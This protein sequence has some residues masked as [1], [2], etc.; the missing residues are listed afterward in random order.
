MISIGSSCLRRKLPTLFGS[1]IRAPCGKTI[2]YL[3]PLELEESFAEALPF[4][5]E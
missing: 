2:P 1:S 3:N 4:P 5:R